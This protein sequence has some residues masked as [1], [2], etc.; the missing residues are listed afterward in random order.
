MCISG[1]ILIF[2]PLSESPKPLVY[3]G[4]KVWSKVF[5]YF[6]LIPTGSIAKHFDEKMAGGL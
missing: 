4:F 6:L 1:E 2:E 3:K 5:A